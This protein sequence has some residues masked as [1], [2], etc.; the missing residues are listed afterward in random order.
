MGKPHNSKHS[1]G[2][3]LLELLAVI[4][5]LAIAVMALAPKLSK[6][7]GAYRSTTG[8]RQIAAALR[9]G[10]AQAV[11]QGGRWHISFE[12]GDTQNAYNSGDCSY[13]PSADPDGGG[14]FRSFIVFHDANNN[15]NR[16]AGEEVASCGIL[17]KGMR[18]SGS[19]GGSNA[20]CN[21]GSSP[22]NYGFIRDGGAKTQSNGTR[23]AFIATVYAH[24]YPSEIRTAVIGTQMGQ[25]CTYPLA[26]TDGAPVCANVRCPFR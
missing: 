26:T 19:G 13:N 22:Q 5:I 23:A 18:W 1:K 17:P 16:N 20:Y 8:A 4:A 2:F 7:V 14:A 15:G 10:R 6:W 24:K 9:A 3:T 25:V 21:G 11:A 12:L